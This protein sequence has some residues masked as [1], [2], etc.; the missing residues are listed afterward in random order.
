M[1]HATSPQDAVATSHR[2]PP[3]AP[4]YNSLHVLLRKKPTSAQLCGGRVGGSRRPPEIMDS[5]SS[6]SSAGS[7]ASTEH[8]MEQIKAQLAQA[9]A[10]EFL[11][12]VGNKCFAK[13]VT[14]PGTSLSGSESSCISRCV[15]RY[16]EAT[17][18]V[19][20]CSSFL[21]REIFATQ[22]QFTKVEREDLG[23]HKDGRVTL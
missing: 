17:G 4:S 20:L 19:S 21:L 16:I 22:T 23:K 9:Y 14:K 3:T 18:I 12:T 15:D 11:E 7:T 6:P 5:F 8:L 13:C 1:A 2:P 10:Q